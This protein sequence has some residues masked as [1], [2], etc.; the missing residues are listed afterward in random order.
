MNVRNTLLSHRAIVSSWLLSL[1]FAGCSAVKAD[2]ESGNS[3]S[4]DEPTPSQP[5]S[6]AET[7]DDDVVPQTPPPAVSDTD[8]VI[9]P[10]EPLPGQDDEG[11]DAGEQACASAASDAELQELALAFAFDVSGSMGE[12]DLPY[13][14]KELKWDPVVAATKAFMESPDVVR[15]SASMVFFPKQDE[16]RCDAELYAEPEVPLQTLPSA[17][18]G[19]A[20]DEIYP[21]RGGTP[22]MAVLQATIEHVEGLIAAGSTAKH[23]IVLITDGMPQGCT[24]EVDSVDAVAEAVAAVSERL[25]VYVIGIANPPTEEEPNPPDNVTSLHQIAQAGGTG[26][27][28]LIDT[29]DS[30]QTV[31]DF[32]A[33]IQTI[34]SNGTS[35]ELAIPAP[36]AGKSF[37]KDKV[38]VSLTADGEPKELGYSEDCAA[39]DA[40]HYDDPAAPKSIVLCEQTCDVVKTYA[41]AA[42]RVEFG[43]ERRVA[44]VK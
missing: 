15:V 25:P 43:C 13:H 14:V 32:D 41:D 40:W 4:S 11:S 6:E 19:E 12:G 30:T 2:E 8:D 5:S 24:E 10:L 35:C 39:E 42:L 21:D 20:I 44:S 18:F 16:N 37:D 27:A 38:N 28:F 7:N 26:D 9:D 1:V 34:R 23:A 31:R 33:A 36:P 22:T 3:A 29:G 17:A